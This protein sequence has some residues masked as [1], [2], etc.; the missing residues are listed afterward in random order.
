MFL[1]FSTRWGPQ[2]RAGLPWGAREKI[3]R[4]LIDRATAMDHRWFTSRFRAEEKNRVIIVREVSVVGWL[5]E[6]VDSPCF[7]TDGLGGP[8]YMNHASFR[9]A[10]DEERIRGPGAGSVRQR[11][12]RRAGGGRDKHVRD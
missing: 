2:L 10:A 8:S 4:A 11:L 9:C 1:N 6:A 12:L 5:S 7:G 3:V